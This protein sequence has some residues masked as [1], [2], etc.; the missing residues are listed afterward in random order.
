MTEQPKSSRDEFIGQMGD[1]KRREAG[2]RK[3]GLLSDLDTL[4]HTLTL[5]DDERFLT[6]SKLWNTECKV[7]QQAMLT[8]HDTNKVFSARGLYGAY[9]LVLNWQADIKGKI[10]K[11][12]SEIHECD[13]ILDPTEPSVTGK[14]QM[15]MNDTKPAG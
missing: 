8:A 15:D 6:L 11:I 7:H 3:E 2:A 10:K 13:E 5:K 12:N 9:H 4:R 1:K 14:G